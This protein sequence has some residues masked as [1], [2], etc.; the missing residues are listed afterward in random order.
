VIDA[1]PQMNLTS[2][3]YGLSTSIDYSTD[4]ESKWMENIK[5]TMI[6]P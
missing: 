2:A 6:N 4:E 5:E 3:M 1:D